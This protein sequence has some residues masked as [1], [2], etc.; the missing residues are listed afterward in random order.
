MS[1]AERADPSQPT[2][3]AGFFTLRNFALG[4]AVLVVVSFTDVVFGWRSFFTRDFSNFGYPIAYH[5][6]QSYRA[7]EV[8]LWNPYNLAG[9]P[10]LAQWNT[11][12]LYPPSLIYILLPLPWSLNLFN[13]L[14]LYLGGL[15]MFCLAR[16]WTNDGRAAGVAGIGY[17]FGG[18]MVSCLMWPNNIA[19]LG[20][21]PTVLL[22]GERAAQAGGRFCVTAALVMALQFLAGAPEITALTWAGLALLVLFGQE[23]GSAPIWLR[24]RRL[25][26]M[27]AITTGLVA[28]QLLPFLELLQR[29]QRSAQ[30]ATGEWT[31]RWSDL[32]NFLVPLFRTFRD[33]D[34]IYFQHSQQWITSFYGGIT[35]VL[36]AL[37][38]VCTARNRRVGL[39]VVVSVLSIGLALGSTGFIY[40]WFRTVVPGLG[41]MRYPIKFIVPA[42]V[43]LPLLAAF[44]ARRWPERPGAPW[45][46]LAFTILLVILSTLL[47]A[48]SRSW[49]TYREV[50]GDT[51]WSGLTCIACLAVMTAL[52]FTGQASGAV[53]ARWLPPLAVA[54]TIYA[55][56][57]FANRHINP[58]V[59]TVAMEM[60]VSTVDPKPR[61]GE[62]RVMVSTAAHELLDAAHF[63]TPEAEVQIPRSALLLNANLLERV[64]KLD[65]FFSLYLPA[66]AALIV[67][68]GRAATSSTSQGLL[69][70]MC[71][72]HVSRPDRPWAWE[73]RT[74]YLPMLSLVPRARPLDSAK[75]F[76]LLFSEEFN[77]REVVFLPPEVTQHVGAA[78]GGRGKILSSRF[79]SQRV[80]AIVETDH[81][82]IMTVA[83][84][85]YPGWRATVD[86]QPV[87]LWTA[88]GAFQAIEVPAGRHEVNIYFQSTSFEI[89]VSITIVS[90]IG[91]WILLWKRPFR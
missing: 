46:G 84:A 57:F 83:Q 30:F 42:L 31:L 89:G 63:T 13:L 21:L 4:L 72:S 76:E 82:M 7:G 66:P 9:M 5:V 28:V 69:D 32:G 34:G 12:A 88:N 50:P 61:L 45:L 60:N 40:D 26:L 37:I 11:L 85:N 6:Q 67:R 59:Q 54:L 70:F 39:L 52:L 29:S 65:G 38:G 33:R 10:F 35:V 20:W 56:L 78:G 18:L 16:R 25:T 55:D 86:N 74:N 17:A 3:A 73:R 80:E 15:G 2:T 8:P 53:S 48:V 23:P 36:F 77:P 49:P 71:V 75:K 64:P 51:L 27:L 79:S 41:L 19:A 87:P 14:H 58:A 22:A 1:Q 68:L 91:C 90:L 43:A 47:L 62:S 24:S 81:P 44:G